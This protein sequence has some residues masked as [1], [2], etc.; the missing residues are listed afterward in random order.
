MENKSST[1]QP[2]NPPEKTQNKKIVTVILVMLLLAAGGALI[3]KFIES[4]ELAEQNRLTQEQL[5]RAYN[6][7]DSMSN[8]LDTR[9]LKIAQLGGEIDT[10][11]QIKMQLEEEK[12]SFR[13][14]V[15]K[16]INELKSTVEGYKELLV[17]Q[18]VEI[19]R[20]KVLNDS[21]M[22]ENTELKV[23]AN[24]LNES[25][26]GLNQSKAQLEEKVATASKLKVERVQI[27]AVSSSG[28]ERPSPFKNRHI[29]HLNI[30]FEILENRVAP[31][32][33]KGILLKITGPD[34]NVIFDV[35]AG[36]GTFMYD[37]RESFYTVKKDILFDRN[38]QQMT[39]LYNKGSDY[40]LGK[41]IL[42]IY[43]DDY[44]MGSTSFIVK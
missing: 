3:Y 20:L 6:D 10:L 18:D 43:T 42:E 4:S 8:E 22:S 21:L 9:I 14:K 33:G 31:I 34:G 32:E 40:D 30:Q 1:S 35:A 24:T 2:G 11:L 17:A 19:A 26:K 7:L 44:K 41:Y 13:K 27:L 28:K 29:D 36:S 16:Q 37:G 23:V 5:D 38:S 15:Y 12:K 39:F 25:I